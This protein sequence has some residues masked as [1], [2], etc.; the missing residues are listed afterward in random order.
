L[1]SSKYKRNTTQ[2]IPIQ[3]TPKIDSSKKIDEKNLTIKN[4]AI[5][6]LA[7]LTVCTAAYALYKYG[8]SDLSAKTP[9]SESI[10]SQN[11]I[12]AP[13][14]KIIT[15][16]T[17]YA[18]IASFSLAKNVKSY[19]LNTTSVL[20][21]NNSK[22]TSLQTSSN[23]KELYSTAHLSDE[24][25]YKFI[26]GPFFQS[27]LIEDLLDSPF[28][29][30][31]QLQ[32]ITN[33]NLIEKLKRRIFNQDL[34]YYKI[35]NRF[36]W[37]DIVILTAQGN[38]TKEL[39]SKYKYIYNE[40]DEAFSLIRKYLFGIDTK[41][42]LAEVFSCDP[43][44]LEALAENYKT[45]TKSNYSPTDYS[46]T[47][48]SFREKCL[49]PILEKHSTPGYQKDFL[50]NVN[51][52]YLEFQKSQSEL[53]SIDY[54]DSAVAISTPMIVKCITSLYSLRI[55]WLNLK[56]QLEILEQ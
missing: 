29:K 26:Q 23:H 3:P 18:P 56:R 25:V 35:K 39:C 38:D 54:F 19:V 42:A 33:C 31:D 43:V 24:L 16:N 8:F 20:F 17:T 32:R 22:E 10:L 28:D 44:C 36:Q 4:V 52:I 34:S 37:D 5:A 27:I 55:E 51:K 50:K 9:A 53:F 21:R 14:A 13:L 30:K 12:E 1:I 49:Y 41:K 2:L 6:A 47:K 40:Q 46:P 11:Q 48:I 15:A 7:T 45:I